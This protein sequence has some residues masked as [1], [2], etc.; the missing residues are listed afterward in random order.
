[1]SNFFTYSWASPD[2][3]FDNAEL[4]Y[5]DRIALGAPIVP[6]TGAERRVVGTWRKIL[7]YTYDQERDLYNGY[8]IRVDLN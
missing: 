2:I 5:E 3:L 6:I 4:E 7:E 1:M 8:T